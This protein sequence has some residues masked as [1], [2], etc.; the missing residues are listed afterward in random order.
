MLDVCLISLAASL[1]GLSLDALKVWPISTIFILL[2]SVAVNLLSSLMI[3]LFTD[4]KE[5]REWQIK[6]TLL[7]R[8]MMKAAQSGNKRLMEKLQK[9][10]QEL[11]KNQSKVQMQ[12]TKIQLFSTIPLLALWYTLMPFYSGNI[13]AIMPFDAPFIGT[14]LNFFWWYFFSSATTN[15]LI[16]RLLGLTFEI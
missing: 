3:R 14:Q 4:I 11:A 2:L 9:D 15:T 7:R 1:V 6:S 12:R 8:E 13:V 5:Y 16:S 10:Q